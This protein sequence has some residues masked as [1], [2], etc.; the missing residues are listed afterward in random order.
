MLK[1]NF[2]YRLA[3]MVTRNIIDEKIEYFL[4]CNE[5]NNYER[6]YIYFLEKK[7]N[8]LYFKLETEFKEYESIKL[9]DLIKFLDENYSSY[10]DTYNFYNMSLLER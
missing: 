1:E 4:V 6:L 3:E 9:D 5:S 2:I 7:N 10:E 8:T